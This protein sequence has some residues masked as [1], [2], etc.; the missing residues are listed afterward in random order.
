MLEQW[1]EQ[2]LQFMKLLTDIVCGTSPLV[3]K[4]YGLLSTVVGLWGSC[5]V[6]IFTA[7]VTC[8]PLL[9]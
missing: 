3:L 9:Q 7:M 8:P 6:E 1:H 5:R 4:C 2:K